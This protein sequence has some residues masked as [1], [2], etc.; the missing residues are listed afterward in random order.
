[1]LKTFLM[2][3]LDSIIIGE[4]PDFGEALFDN[5]LRLK[6]TKSKA[7]KLKAVGV[8]I[9]LQSPFFGA[10]LMNFCF[11]RRGYFAVGGEIILMYAFLLVGA[12]L[13]MATVK[14]EETN[15]KAEND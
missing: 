1:M 3:T 4:K 7:G 2:N 12:V 8:F 6:T 9:V 15:G 11:E 14:E 10:L 13:C 5:M